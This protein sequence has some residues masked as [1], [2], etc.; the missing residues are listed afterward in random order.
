MGTSIAVGYNF[1]VVAQNTEGIAELKAIPKPDHSPY[2]TLSQF[3]EFKEAQVADRQWMVDAIY[4]LH[5]KF[6]TFLLGY[7]NTVP[8]P[9]HDHLK[10]YDPDTT[11]RMTDGTN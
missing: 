1:R 9:D 11:K 10:G 2:L 8:P 4:N 3:N 7:M 5:I 6:D